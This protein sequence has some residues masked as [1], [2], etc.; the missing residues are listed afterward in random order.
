M[1]GLLPGP[2]P[3]RRRVV[4]AWPGHVGDP[5]ASHGDEVFNRQT[6]SGRVVVRDVHVLGRGRPDEGIDHRYGGRD[7][8]GFTYVGP[9]ARHDEAVDTP[10]DQH[11][12]VVA[13]TNRVVATV[14][15]EE[16]KV[17]GPSASSAPSITG[18]LNRPEP[19]SVMSPT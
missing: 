13:L 18:M 11:G 3:R 8:Q 6:C 1:E 15:E 16:A 9:P 10:A 19:S 4:M 14:A 5:A 12:E 17:S 2:Q 7:V